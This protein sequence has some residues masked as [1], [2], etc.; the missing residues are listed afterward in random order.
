[1]HK[2]TK[3]VNLL[4]YFLC[5]LH[6]LYFSFGSKQNAYW[7]KVLHRLLL[8]DTVVLN[9]RQR[10]AKR[11]LIEENRERKRQEQ[12]ATKEKHDQCFHESMTDDDRAVIDDIVCAYEQTTIKITKAY[13]LV[14]MLR[15][16]A[17]HMHFANCTDGSQARRNET[18]CPFYYT[19]HT[20]F[21][22]LCATVNIWRSTG[23]CTTVTLDMSLYKSI[24]GRNIFLW[25]SE[26]GLKQAPMYCA[27]VQV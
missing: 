12:T 24:S 21:N 11:K 3:Y 23:G 14:S 20:R 27:C 7:F 25:L 16:Y 9:E 13:T 18:R 10:V 15:L 2:G 1:M 8:V 4:L 17:L 5:D 26:N 22:I 6:C 19:R